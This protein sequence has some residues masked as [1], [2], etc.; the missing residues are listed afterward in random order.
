M[1]ESEKGFSEKKENALERRVRIVEIRDRVLLKDRS[2]DSAVMEEVFDKATLMAVYSLLNQGVISKIFGVI[3]SGKESRIYTG[4]G[5]KEDRIAIKIYLATSAEFKKG[6]MMYIR[7]DERFK[8][9]RT[10]T[11]TLVNLWALKEFR[12]LQQAE[13]AGVRVPSPLKVNGNVLLMEFIGQRGVPAPLLRESP[14]EHPGRVYDQIAEAVRK[15]YQKARLI[16]GDLSEYNIMLADSTP[17][18]FDFAQAVP[19]EHPMARAF[20]ERDLIRLNEYFA[21]IGV[22]V[23]SLDRLTSWVI[24]EH[25]NES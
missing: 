4:M 25:A 13:Q 5:S 24:G 21:K 20:L 6:R 7:G 9:T 1:A 8:S 19:P 11:R 2:S 18:L 22:S 15:L 14:L 23:P 3:K 16:H 17:V 10:D 12:N